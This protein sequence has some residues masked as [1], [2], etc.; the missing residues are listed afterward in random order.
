MPGVGSRNPGSCRP[1]ERASSPGFRRIRLDR[2]LKSPYFNIGF[3]TVALRD[4]FLYNGDPISVDM[5][6]ITFA[7]KEITNSP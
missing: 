1:L 6:S 5:E 4:V 2:K 3:E 7:G